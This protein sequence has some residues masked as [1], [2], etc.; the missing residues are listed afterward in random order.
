VGD[1]ADCDPAWGVGERAASKVEP[2]GNEKLR[3]VIGEEVLGGKY[4]V[5]PWRKPAGLGSLSSY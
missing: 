4:G 2:K 3:D 1:R 5:V